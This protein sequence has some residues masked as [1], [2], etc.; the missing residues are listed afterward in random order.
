PWPRLVAGALLVHA[1]AA[2]ALPLTSNDLFSNLAYGRLSHLGWNPYLHAPRALPPD[3]PFLALVGRRWL[4]TPIVYGP[5]L[6]ALDAAV[7]YFTNVFHAL[8]A[9]KLTLAA[10]GSAIVL[11]TR[12]AVAG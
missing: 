3:D 7:G 1:A 11:A 8:A 4:D 2:L 5:I 12:R 6:T 10:T 9:F